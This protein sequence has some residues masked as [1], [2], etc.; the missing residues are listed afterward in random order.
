MFNASKIDIKP[1]KTRGFLSH[2]VLSFSKII[3]KKNLGQPTFNL[4]IFQPSAFSPP[5]KTKEEIEVIV[6]ALDQNVKITKPFSLISI[7][8]I[9]KNKTS[10]LQN[11]RTL[12]RSSTITIR[13]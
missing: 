7:L 12:A 5:K 9:S 1:K 11:N 10:N 2:P 13:R 8:A 3:I 4:L 6:K